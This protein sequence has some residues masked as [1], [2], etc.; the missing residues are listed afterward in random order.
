[1][2]DDPKNGCVADYIMATRVG[3]DLSCM[4]RIFKNIHWPQAIKRLATKKDLGP[5]KIDRVVVDANRSV[6]LPFDIGKILC[7]YPRKGKDSQEVFKCFRSAT[8]HLSWL[9]GWLAS[10]VEIC[11]VYGRVVDKTRLRKAFWWT[12][13]F[14]LSSICLNSLQILEAKARIFVWHWTKSLCAWSYS[15]CTVTMKFMW[16]SSRQ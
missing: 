10:G 15:N 2:R 4:T 14:Q 12:I 6:N 3:L 8:Y 13:L 5:F 9:E 7:T 16:S 11:L 1:M